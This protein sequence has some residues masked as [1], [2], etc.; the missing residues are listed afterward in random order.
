M[1][2]SPPHTGGSATARAT[3]RLPRGH[4]RR[5]IARA[6]YLFPEQPAQQVEADAEEAAQAQVIAGDSEPADA[7][8]GLDLGRDVAAR[9][10]ARAKND[11]STTPGTV[12]DRRLLPPTGRR[13][14]VR[15]RAD[16][17]TGGYLADL[18][19]RVR[20]SVPLSLSR[21]ATAPRSSATESTPY[22]R[23]REPDARAAEGWRCSGRA[24]RAPRCPPASGR[25]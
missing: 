16:R 12:R 3:T 22:W 7:Q 24:A 15:R 14:P 21:R 13:R 17:A 2:R 5:R 11:G 6:A 18:G 4:R 10:I 1:P 20:R 19:D 25:A 23:R 9:V 8:A